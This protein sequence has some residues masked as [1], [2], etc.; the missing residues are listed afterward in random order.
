MRWTNKT[1]E[2]SYEEGYYRF[3]KIFKKD[4]TELV[5]DGE[6]NIDMDGYHET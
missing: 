1:V 4:V 6:I 3:K 5:F 2:N